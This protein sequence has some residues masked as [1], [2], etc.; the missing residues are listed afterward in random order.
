VAF[1]W[2]E[3]YLSQKQGDIK[4]DKSRTRHCM[5]HKLDRSTLEFIGN[6]HKPEQRRRMLTKLLQST[7]HLIQDRRLLCIASGTY[8]GE[9]PPGQ[10]SPTLTR[11]FPFT[12]KLSHSDNHPITFL[13]PSCPPSRR[14]D[15][16]PLRPPPHPCD[17]IQRQIPWLQTC[18]VTCVQHKFFRHSSFILLTSFVGRGAF[19]HLN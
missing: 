17:P 5:L 3:V 19:K 18:H 4:G 14:F 8:E 16:R 6:Y 9:L 11:T 2:V 12:E 7:Q 13:S 15:N 1:V 10:P